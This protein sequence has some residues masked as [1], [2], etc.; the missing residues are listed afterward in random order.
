M[1]QSESPTNGWSVARIVAAALLASA[2]TGCSSDASRFSSLMPSHDELTTASINNQRAPVPA[3]SVGNGGY[4]APQMGQQDYGARSQAMAQPYPSQSYPSEPSSAARRSSQPVAVER[5]ALAAPSDA[6]NQASS[7]SGNRQ[8]ALAQPMPASAASQQPRR[9]EPASSGNREQLVTGSNPSRVAAQPASLPDPGNVP[10]P[11]NSPEQKVALL[12]KPT[13]S[14]VKQEGSADSANAGNSDSDPGA[15]VVRPGDSL[16]KIARDTGTS[17]D[18]LKSANNL[19]SVT[20]RVGQKL[21]VPSQGA[22][23]VKTASVPASSKPSAEPAVVKAEPVVAKADPQPSSA[24]SESVGQVASADPQASAPQSTGI[25]KYRWP[26]TGAV[27]A[28]YGQNVGGKRNDGI[29][30][31]VPEGTPIKAAENGVVIYAG[32]G[33]KELGN[34][35]LVRHQDGTVTVYGHADALSVQRGQKVQRG[36]QIAKSGMSGSAKRPQVHFEVRKDASP[37]DPMTFLE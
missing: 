15:Y 12:P 23:M 19:S 4:A 5:S 6:P 13:T 37:V 17:V 3:A 18:A 29:D 22:D 26:V 21:K 35:V 1:R 27:I 25:G 32:N 2:A 11:H 9:I 10:V 34:T 33:L 16:A 20:I 7:S 24:A 8:M 30:I 14:R 36:Q 28:K 31:S